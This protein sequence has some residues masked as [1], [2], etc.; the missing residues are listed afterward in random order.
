MVKILKC[1]PLILI[2][3]LLLAACGGP[4]DPAPNAQP[5]APAEENAGEA[6]PAQQDAPLE[7]GMILPDYRAQI[8]DLPEGMT[9]PGQLTM[10]GDTLYLYGGGLL[11]AGDAAG[12]SW[13]QIA[14]SPAPEDEIVAL[15]AG[16][17]RLFFLCRTYE[18]DGEQATESL[19]VLTYDPQSG[20]SLGSKP[21]DGLTEV[22]SVRCLAA[23]GKLI[24]SAGEELCVYSEEAELL[25][26]PE[27]PGPVLFL[28]GTPEGVLVCTE[29]EGAKP[30][31]R[32]DTETGTLTELCAV[33]GEETPELSYLSQDGAFWA[34]AEGLWSLDTASGESEKLLSWADLCVDA[35]SADGFCRSAAGDVFLANGFY[36]VLYRISAYDGPPLKE[37]TAAC[38]NGGYSFVTQA[39]ARFN[40]ASTE[41]YVRYQSYG[42]TE[43][44]RLVT[45]LNSGRGPDILIQD[46]TTNFESVEMM[47]TNE[48]NIRRTL[49]A[50]LLPL[51]DADPELS[52]EDFLPGLLEGMTEGG[53]LYRLAPCFDFNSVTAPETLTKTLDGWDMETLTALGGALPENTVLFSDWKREFFM[54]TLCAFASVAYVDYD[55]MSC[56]FDD[57]SFSAWLELAGSQTFL[58]E[59]PE[60]LADSAHSLLTT[61]A[62]RPSTLAMYTGSGENYEYLGFPGPEG[63]LPYLTC[64]VCSFSILKDSKNQ[65]GAW[66]FLRQFLTPELQSSISGVGFG[67]PVM[68]AS[69]DSYMEASLENSRERGLTQQD[70][71]R[72]KAAVENNLGMARG[73]LVSSMIKEEAGKYFAGQQSLEKTV[74]LLQSKVRLYLAEQ[75]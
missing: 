6:A 14:L 4:S 31:Y 72:F 53:G 75:A 19:S 22:Y 39:I 50:D 40:S 64:N 28:G 74:E 29:A 58:S 3:A 55:T 26:Q 46:S 13:R 23:E 67:L 54:E 1:L 27:L 44:D 8:L 52:R 38:L 18:I 20:E 34:G 66:S 33:G 45:E 5:T 68:E 48:L 41:Y 61:G 51:I 21:L 69:F 59:L 43:Q 2:L 24:V 57:P 37:I 15:A 36:G 7:E 71:D 12:G 10:A 60:G 25:C 16:E 63:P 56:R 62:I 70:I 65:E 30:L 42:G 47:K 11:F 73:T 32:L 35:I 49:L 17:N 9:R